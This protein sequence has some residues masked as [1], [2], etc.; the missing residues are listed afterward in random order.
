MLCA[1]CLNES[2]IIQLSNV[3]APYQDCFSVLTTDR[4]TV[5]KNLFSMQTKYKRVF[6]V[7]KWT[8]CLFLVSKYF[9][10]HTISTFPDLTSLA[11]LSPAAAWAPSS[12]WAAP[13][14]AASAPRPA[15]SASAA[16]APAT[17]ASHPGQDFVSCLAKKRKK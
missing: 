12:R 9:I 11:P 7:V 14:P 5:N 17:A 16:P 1:V 2:L 8:V 4:T 13:P 3:V 15:P 10:H 6:V